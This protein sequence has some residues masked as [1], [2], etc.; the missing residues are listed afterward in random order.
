MLGVGKMEFGR[1]IKEKRIKKGLSMRELARRSGV[2]QPYI[3]QIE[4]GKKGIP[5]PEMLFKLAPHLGESYMEL[6]DAAGYVSINEDFT[7]EG[8]DFLKDIDKGVD[9]ID[10]IKH[11]PTIDGR[12][13]TLTELELAVHVIKNLRKAKEV[14]D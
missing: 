13:I 8:M 10:L 9:M 4:N 11:K 14:D 6:M 7:D 12:E 1:Y 3:S 2:S 5:A